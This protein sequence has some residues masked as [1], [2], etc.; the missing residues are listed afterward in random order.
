MFSA[1]LKDMKKTLWAK[2]KKSISECSN[3]KENYKILYTSL[4]LSNR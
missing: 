1:F 3:G 2:F 4:V